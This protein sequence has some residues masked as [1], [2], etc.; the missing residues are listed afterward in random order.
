MTDTE[1]QQREVVLYAPPSD[2][3]GALL[4]GMLSLVLGL[5]FLLLGRWQLP[6]LVA[7]CLFFVGGVLLLL[8]YRRLAHTPVLIINAEGIFSLR[9]MLRM[10]LKWEEIDAIYCALLTRTTLAFTVD[11]S[12][13]GL[14]S[15][16]ARHGKRPPRRL[17]MTIPQSALSIPQSNLPLPIAQLT[18]QIREQFAA[19][20]E[21]YH[22]T[23]DEG[24]VT[25]QEPK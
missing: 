20:I 3:I 25:G 5:A 24:Q 8:L 17:D 18:A 21:R 7:S 6:A 16:F 10:T 9:P 23:L 19:Q 15:F 2:R 22:I 14:V 13:A 1:N 4:F 12:P 11:L